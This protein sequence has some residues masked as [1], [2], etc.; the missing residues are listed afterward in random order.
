MYHFAPARRGRPPRAGPH[1]PGGVSFRGGSGPARRA[2]VQSLRPGSAKLSTFHLT[3]PFGDL[4]CLHH[5]S[6]LIFA[7]QS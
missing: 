3:C 2:V 7:Q 4:G 1:L 5:R 6:R